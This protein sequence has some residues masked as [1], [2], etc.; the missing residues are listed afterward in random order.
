MHLRMIGR[1]VSVDFLYIIG[2]LGNKSRLGCKLDLQL[3]RLPTFLKTSARI[4]MRSFTKEPENLG[5]PCKSHDLKFNIVATR[6]NFIEIGFV[7]CAVIFLRVEF[8]S[9]QDMSAIKPQLVTRSL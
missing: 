1:A 6:L 4:E 3:S 7:T 9:L 5:F 2:V 8:S